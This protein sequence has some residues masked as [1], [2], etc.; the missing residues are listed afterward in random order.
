M[1]GI[2]ERHKSRRPR[3]AELRIFRVKGFENHLVFYRPIE[4]GIE[5]VRILHGARDIDDALEVDEA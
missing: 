3:L 5:V 4:A 1:P 2:G